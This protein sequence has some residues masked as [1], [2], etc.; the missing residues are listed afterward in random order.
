[1][2]WY[3]FEEISPKQM[4]NLRCTLLA[5]CSNKTAFI[6]GM[7]LQCYFVKWDCVILFNFC[8][9]YTVDFCLCVT[10]AQLWCWIV[11]R[12]ALSSTSLWPVTLRNSA[13]FHKHVSKGVDIFCNQIFKCRYEIHEQIFIS[14][15]DSKR[16]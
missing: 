9:I 12:I 15:W 1:M 14:L 5:V 7:V 3:Y 4:P 8:L 13:R 11:N 2:I 10:S 16:H 6:C